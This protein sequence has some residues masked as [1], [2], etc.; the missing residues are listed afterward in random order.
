MTSKATAALVARLMAFP[1]NVEVSPDGCGAPVGKVR[2][3]HTR[4]AADTLRK[5]AQRNGL[6]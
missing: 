6:R 3:E 1:Q 2:D 5:A 4:P